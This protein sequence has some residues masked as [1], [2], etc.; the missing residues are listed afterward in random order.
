MASKKTMIIFRDFVED[1][2]AMV[3][4]C[5]GQQILA[6]AGVL[7]GRQCTAYPAV[8]PEVEGAGAEWYEVNAGASNAHVHGRLVTA[9][10]WPAHPVWMR[11]FLQ[12]LGSRIEP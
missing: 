3:P 6:A 5:H 2:E 10:A 7:A 1:Y 8:R 12:V 9:P 4:F 11:K